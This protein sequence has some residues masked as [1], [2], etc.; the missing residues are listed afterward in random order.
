[1]F[2]FDAL[3][4]AKH[5]VIIEGAREDEFSAVKNADGVDS[6]QT[7]RDDQMRQFARW[8]IAAGAAIEVD[9]SGLPKHAIEISMLVA[10]SEQAFVAYW[11][12][13]AE[14]P[15]LDQPLHL[16]SKA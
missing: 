4:F 10:D 9:D 5:P 12:S 13:L 6:P 14:R 7:C 2:V 16:S 15:P 3:P 1:M 11:E 8:L